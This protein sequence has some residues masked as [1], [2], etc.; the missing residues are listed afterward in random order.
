MEPQKQL[1]ENR[2][3]I[4]YF[5]LNLITFDIY[6]AVMISNMSK[7]INLIAKDGKRTFN[8]L[9]LFLMGISGVLILLLGALPI[10]KYEDL[11]LTQMSKEELKPIISGGFIML[12]GCLILVVLSVIVLIWFYRFT[13]RISEELKRRS[14]DYGFNEDT[15]W[16]WIIGSCVVSIIFSIACTVF[17]IDNI[18]SDLIP[19][20]PAVLCYIYS[21]KL[22][23]AMNLLNKD[24]NQKAE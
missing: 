10:L 5:L 18:L 14:I 12:F 7:E 22:I 1:R 23:K 2:S 19:G 16:I 4:K 24:Y 6:E 8:Y 20:I 17:G 21:Y 15:Y 11:D 3:F 13:K 9:Y